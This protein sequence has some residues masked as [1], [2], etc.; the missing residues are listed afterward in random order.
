MFLGAFIVPAITLLY[1][2]LLGALV[3]II[4]SLGPALSAKNVKVAEVFAK[5]A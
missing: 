1:G 2:P 3:A 4:G 5:V